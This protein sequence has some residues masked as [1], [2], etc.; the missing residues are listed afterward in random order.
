MWSFNST[1]HYKLFNDRT[2]PKYLKL[3]PFLAKLK[4]IFTTLEFRL[5]RPLN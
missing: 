5:D 2:I 1:L 4:L 3:S